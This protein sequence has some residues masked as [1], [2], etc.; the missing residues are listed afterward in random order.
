MKKI[1]KFRLFIL[2]IISAVFCAIAA[3]VDFYTGNLE[4]GIFMTALTVMD[5]L[6]YKGNR[7]LYK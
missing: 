6:L 4:I 2:P 1:D 3:V 7:R 5:I